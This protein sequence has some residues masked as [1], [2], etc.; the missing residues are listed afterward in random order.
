MGESSAEGAI[1]ETMEEAQAAVE[2]TL[3]CPVMYEAI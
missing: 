1:R 2:V 3:H